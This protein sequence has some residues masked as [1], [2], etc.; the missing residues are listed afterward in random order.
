MKINFTIQ[1]PDADNPTKSQK[2]VCADLSKLVNER[3]DASRFTASFKGDI[4]LYLLLS[5]KRTPVR[6]KEIANGIFL[7]FCEK[8]TV[9]GAKKVNFCVLN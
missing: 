2:E 5:E 3:V 9:L 1:V 4:N 6:I 8:I 7:G